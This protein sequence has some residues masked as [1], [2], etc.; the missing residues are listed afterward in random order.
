MYNINRRGAAK[1]LSLSLKKFLTFS[2]SSNFHLHASH[3]PGVINSVFNSF[4]RL[5]VS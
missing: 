1:T 3:I 5:A 4:S 2:D